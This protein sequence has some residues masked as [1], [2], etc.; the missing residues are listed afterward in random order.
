MS[1]KDMNNNEKLYLRAESSKN[2]HV[3]VEPK[4]YHSEEGQVQNMAPPPVHNFNYP[5]PVR[6]TQTSETT[7]MLDGICQLQLTLQQNVLTNSKQVEYYMSQNADL[8]TEMI[9]GQNRRALDPTM[10]AIPMFKGKEPEKCL[11]WVNRI[12]NICDQSECPMRQELMNKSEPVVQNFIKT[13]NDMS[14]DKEVVEEILKYF[15][16]IPTL[17]HAIM[18]LRTLIQGEEKTIMTYNQKYRTL[19]K[20]VEWKLVKKIDSY[21]KMEQYLGSI[22]FPIR[23]SIRNNIYFKSKHAPKMLGEAMRKAKELYM[24]HV[25][26]MEGTEN[27]QGIAG[28]SE[29]VI[30]EVN[31]PQKS[32]LNTHRP[33]RNRNSSEISLNQ[34]VFVGQLK[35]QTRTLSEENIQLLR[36][37]YTQIMVNLTQLLDT[38]DGQVSGGQKGTDR[39]TNQDRT[40][41]SENPSSKNKE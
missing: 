1:E 40:D 39:I 29:V 38:V 30:N 10:M 32:G 7:V 21:V 24:K 3:V 5:P 36:G 12:R 8:F 15:S 34:G 2:M 28:T 6:L 22:I 19:V 17:S 33:W 20:R 16:D 11:D 37:S 31:A 14:M 27:K 25:Y 26:T 35:S 41:N 9:R 4:R 23:K 18:K 13:M